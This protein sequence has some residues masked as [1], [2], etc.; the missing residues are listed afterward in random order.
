L[1]KQVRS[2]VTRAAIVRGAAEAFDRFGYGATSLSDVIAL[3]GVTKGALYFHFSSKQELAQAVIRQQHASSV[4]PA[5]DQVAGSAPGLE[6]VIQ[7]SQQ[8]ASQL[9][10]DPVVRAGI[11]LTMETGTFDAAMPDPYQEWIDATT[12]LLQRAADAGEL[13]PSVQPEMVARF[14]C[15]AFTGVQVLSQVLTGRTDLRERVQEM[16]ELLLPGLVPER[17]LP[18]YRRIARGATEETVTAQA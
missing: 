16:W 12:T 1:A 6:T 3:A 10:N 4:G 14:A 8:L 9:Q 17:K 13:R 2:E 7:L 11:R 18:Y 5:V 15:G